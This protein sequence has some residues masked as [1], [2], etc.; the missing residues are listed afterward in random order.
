MAFKEACEKASP[1][2]LEPIMATE[3]ETP[4]DFMGGV[5]GDLN[6]RR[7]RILGMEPRGQMQVIRA[8]VPV[9]QMFGYAT[10]LRSMTQGRATYTMQFAH[11][12]EVPKNIADEIIAKMRG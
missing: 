5:V 4:D 9:A 8:E 12:Q 1:V 2:I 6:A 3:V 7:G 11:Y 10:A